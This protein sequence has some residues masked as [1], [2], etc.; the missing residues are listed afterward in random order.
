MWSRRPI[1]TKSIGCHFSTNGLVATISIVYAI[2]MTAQLLECLKKCAIIRNDVNF[3]SKVGGN[4][5]T[6]STDHTIRNHTAHGCSGNWKLT[7]AK[8]LSKIMMVCISWRPSSL[9]HKAHTH[10]QAWEKCTS[11]WEKNILNFGI[12][13]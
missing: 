13:H 7:T 2:K 6:F 10:T 1:D 8:L 9:W 4:H 12:L 3:C 11:I 5:F